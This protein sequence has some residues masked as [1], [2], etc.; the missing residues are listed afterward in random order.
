VEA[1]LRAGHTDVH[2]LCLALS[3]WSE[4]LR[5]LQRLAS[6]PPRLA[7]VRSGSAGLAC[8]TRTPE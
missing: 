5:L 1:E 2:G 8:R 7:H 6:V 4:E 3:D